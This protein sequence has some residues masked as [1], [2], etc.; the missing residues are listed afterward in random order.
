MLSTSWAVICERASAKPPH[1]FTPK[2]LNTHINNSSAGKTGAKT[3]KICG[4]TILIKFPHQYSAATMKSTAM[5]HRP[6][7]VLTLV[8]SESARSHNA[9]GLTDQ[10]NSYRGG[11]H[12]SPPGDVNHR[13]LLSK[14]PPNQVVIP[15]ITKRRIQL[16]ARIPTTQKNNLR[17]PVITLISH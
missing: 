8:T 10:N 17:H 7:M 3:K 13:E 5:G 15:N 1:N 11:R 16:A 4:E 2:L 9:T 6:I 12:G 14:S